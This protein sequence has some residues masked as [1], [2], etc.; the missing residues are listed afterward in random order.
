M[1]LESSVNDDGDM[2]WGWGS[3]WDGVHTGISKDVIKAD[4]CL[5]VLSVCG[6]LV[7]CVKEY[8]NCTIE[9]DFM[10]IWFRGSIFDSV[11]AKGDFIDPQ[12]L[13]LMQL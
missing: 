1:G 13:A 9:I 8:E 6:I 5:P 2:G 11:S 7:S 4:E 12:K 3:V 10:E